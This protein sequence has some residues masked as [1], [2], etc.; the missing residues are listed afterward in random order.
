[1][2]NLF[3]HLSPGPSLIVDFANWIGKGWGFVCVLG[4]FF[5]CF[6][7]LLVVL[8]Y[9]SHKCLGTSFW[10]FF[11]NRFFYLYKIFLCLYAL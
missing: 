6:L 7:R 8:L 11:L 1:M 10:C 2:L 3:H 4:V 5:G 9:I